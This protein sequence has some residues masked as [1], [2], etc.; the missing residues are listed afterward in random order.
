[1]ICWNRCLRV[2]NRVNH[3]EERKSLETEPNPPP[4]VTLRRS[5]GDLAFLALLYEEEIEIHFITRLQ[6]PYNLILSCSSW[7]IP[8]PK[9]GKMRP[10]IPIRPI[11]PTC[12]FIPTLKKAQSISWCT[13]CFFSVWPKIKLVTLLHHKYV[14][15]LQ[16]WLMFTLA[17]KSQRHS[18][19]LVL[20]STFFMSEKKNESTVFFNG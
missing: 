12:V 20:P 9:T 14:I 6:N 5:F 13:F 17:S 8:R 7:C 3:S 10:K 16:H 19:P 11:C 18:N 1:M 2:E 15:W 4:S